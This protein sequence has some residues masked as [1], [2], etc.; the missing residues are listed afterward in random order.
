MK[1]TRLW[2]VKGWLHGVWRGSGVNPDRSRFEDVDTL[3]AADTREQAVSLAGRF[4]RDVYKREFSADHVE[5][6]LQAEA[7]AYHGGNVIVGQ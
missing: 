6:R 3:V 1:S 7:T 2:L 4:L 5:T